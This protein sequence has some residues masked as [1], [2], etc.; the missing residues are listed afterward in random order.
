MAPFNV[1]LLCLL[2][3]AAWTVY[4]WYCL[5]LNYLRARKI[6]VP[7]VIIPISHGNLLWMIVDKKFFIPVFERLPFGSGSF[8]RYNW[9]GWEF[10]DK[11]KSHLELGDVFVIAN[12]GRNRLYVCN[13]KAL[14][15]VFQRRMDFPRPLELFGIIQRTGNPKDSADYNRDGECFR[16]EPLHSKRSDL[17]L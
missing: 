10:Q 11:N 8:V 12:P 16:A 17:D 14:L 13:A 1:L 2:P 4:S 9:R 7:V 3:P 15:D 5:L 6:G